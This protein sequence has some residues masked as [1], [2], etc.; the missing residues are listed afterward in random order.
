[1]LNLEVAFILRIAQTASKSELS[2]F[3]A[4]DSSI[5]L[6]PFISMK[7]NLFP[8]YQEIYNQ[9]AAFFPKPATNGNVCSSPNISSEELEVLGFLLFSGLI[10]SISLEMPSLMLF[11]ISFANKSLVLEN[12]EKTNAHKNK[13]ILFIKKIYLIL[14]SYANKVIWKNLNIL[15]QI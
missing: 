12:I 6:R 2:T 5:T 7:K 10:S 1:M 3:S 15:K 9:W 4:S 14:S 8:H 13:M 11:P